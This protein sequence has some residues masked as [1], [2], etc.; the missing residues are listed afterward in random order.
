ME[1][2]MADS[3]IRNRLVF[4]TSVVVR[5]AIRIRAGLDGIRPAEVINRALASYLDKEIRLA[6]ERMNETGTEASIE[7]PKPAR[8]RKDERT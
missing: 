7:Q 8:K 3:R 5:R 4:E 6:Q 2:P 1:N